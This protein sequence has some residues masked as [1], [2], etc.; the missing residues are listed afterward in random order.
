M[1][2]QRILT[3]KAACSI[4]ARPT[5]GRYDLKYVVIMKQKGDGCDYTIGCGINFEIFEAE[6]AGDAMMKAKELWLGDD[7]EPE[8][9]GP[10]YSGD[11]ELAYMHLCRFVT[12]CPIG[13]WMGEINKEERALRKAEEEVQERAEYDRLRQKYG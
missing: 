4:H 12:G 5:E 1:E 3:P 6:N 9:G 2:V 7:Y 11:Y 10:L 8:E 13:E